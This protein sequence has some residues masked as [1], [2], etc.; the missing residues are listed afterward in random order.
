M[1]VNRIRR[2]TAALGTT[3]LVTAGIGAPPVRAAAHRTAPQ[4]SRSAVLAASLGVSEAEVRSAMRTSAVPGTTSLASALAEQ[5]GVDTADVQRVVDADRP[6]RGHRPD[7]TTLLA[8][9]VAGLRLDEALVSAAFDRVDAAK[10]AEH[11]ARLA[12]LAA[13]LVQS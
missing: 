2:A 8:S 12:G 11:R 10:S 3:A 7:R 4:Q 6:K 9:L 1:T 13:K 5:L